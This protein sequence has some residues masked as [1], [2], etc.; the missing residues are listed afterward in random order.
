MRDSAILLQN[1]IKE[2]DPKYGDTTVI[3]EIPAAKHITITIGPSISYAP[4][5]YMGERVRYMKFVCPWWKTISKEIAEKVPSS[6][7]IS[8]VVNTN[9][10]EIKNII[11]NSIKLGMRGF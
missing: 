4:L 1:K 6:T 5:E 10:E 11:V 2:V 8:N 3:H 7:E 9:I